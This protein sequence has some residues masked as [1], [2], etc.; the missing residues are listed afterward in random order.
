MIR[1][2]RIDSDGH[3]LRAEIVQSGDSATLTCTARPVVTDLDADAFVVARFRGDVRVM[4]REG[5]AFVEG[6]Q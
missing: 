1:L 5:W 4:V 6:G 2:Q 3:T